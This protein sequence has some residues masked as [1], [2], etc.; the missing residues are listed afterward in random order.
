MTA[1]ILEAAV[2]SLALSLM[3]WLALLVLRPRNPH[4]HKTVWIAVLV[5]SL[6]MPF[7]MRLPLTAAVTVP[8]SMLTLTVAKIAPIRAIAAPAWF[9]FGALYL[10]VAIALA[11][12]FA[13]GLH[14]MWRIRRNARVLNE[15]WVGSLDV[16]VSGRLASPVT[17]ASTI[18]LP[19]E[20]TQ[21]SAQQRA[22]V[23][24]HE[25]SHVRQKDCYVVW[26]ARANTCLFWFN[27]LTW[28]LARRIGSLAETTSD[29]AALEAIDRCAYAELLLAFA[30]QPSPGRLAMAMAHSNVRRRIERIISGIAPSATLKARQRIV[31]AALLLP[32][33]AVATVPMQTPQ[34]A[35][36]KQESASEPH[37]TRW[38]DM[39]ELEKYYPPEASQGGIEGSV[40][41]AVT[42]DRAGRATDTL[43]LSEE[44]LDMGFG[45]AA[46][47]LAHTNT[48]SN[49]TGQPVQLNFRVKFALG[50]D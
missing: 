40:L 49:P 27:P 12:R 5:A 2:R 28:W 22:A 38:G 1:I 33:V 6:A 10:L 7:I 19:E 34:T 42:L 30:Q 11:V 29:D 14:S 17:F 20:F 32:V 44:P 26:L 8:H 47:Q 46:S 48:Y 37:I 4:V 45:A 15:P 36:A 13:A 21:W 23:L 43:I 25:A 24:A 35:P 3:A 18:V 39:A 50:E 16:R 41:I 31:I 9:S